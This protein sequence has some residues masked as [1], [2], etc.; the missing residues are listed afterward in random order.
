[1]HRKLNLANWESISFHLLKGILEFHG[2]QW[3]LQALQIYW[4]LIILKIVPT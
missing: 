3:V 2:K 1:M 4:K